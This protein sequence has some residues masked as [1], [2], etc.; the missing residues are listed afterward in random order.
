MLAAP[1]RAEQAR[2]ALLHRFQHAGLLGVLRMR[3]MRESEVEPAVKG[4]D[5]ELT[6]MCVLRRVR[7]SGC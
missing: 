4:T 7:R 5:K 6:H 2:A 1:R 3:T